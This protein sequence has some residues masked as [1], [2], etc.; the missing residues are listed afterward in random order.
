MATSP[1]L[2]PENPETPEPKVNATALELQRRQTEAAELMAASAGAGDVPVTEAGIY[3]SILLACI[4]GRV[5]ST[6]DGMQVWAA[7]L[8]RDYIAKYPPIA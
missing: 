2:N 6:S 3:L 7:D 1:P 4:K 8:T 5:A